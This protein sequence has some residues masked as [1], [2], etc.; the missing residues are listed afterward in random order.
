M[1][2]P[3]IIDDDY[4]SRN[5]ISIGH[6]TFTSHFDSGNLKSA[7]HLF[8]NTYEI[9]T[10]PDCAG[11]AYETDYTSWFHFGI[12]GGKKGERVRIR[13][14]K[15]N[16]HPT[17]YDN[18]MRPVYRSSPLQKKWHRIK[19]APKH[20]LIGG[21]SVLTF[22][23]V[24]ERA[25]TMACFAFCYPYS[26]LELQQK[27]LSLDER[28][29]KQDMYY[30]RELLI[31][32]ADG[33]RID[34]ITLS[35]KEGMSDEAEPR[36]PKL[37]P[38]QS[39]PRARRF[40][41]KRVVFVSAR[42]HPG[43]TP[44]SHALNGLLDFLLLPDDPRARSLRREFVF[45]IIPMLNPDGVARGHYRVDNNGANLNRYY[46][47][48]S[49]DQHGSIY[50]AKQIVLHHHSRA[51]LFMYLDLHAHATKRGCFVY[52]NSLKSTEQQTTNQLYARLVGINSANFEYDQC[53][54]TEKN[55]KSK[56][57]R[58]NGLSK[59]G[60][61]RVAV[62]RETG[63]THIYTLECNYNMGRRPTYLPA[64]TGDQGRASP[65][66]CRRTSVPKYRPED[67]QDVGKGLMVALLDMFELNPWTRIFKSPW[68]TY[69]GV[70]EAVEQ[71]IRMNTKKLARRR[72][73]AAGNRNIPLG[74]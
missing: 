2:D 24:F 58:D 41:N 36:I 33:R 64:A 10:S 46:Q 18:D 68:R 38:D 15:L 35:S 34:L 39:R 1:D 56:D 59:E 23:H 63:L 16:K 5:E 30:H 54:F 52:G 8:E 29:M 28:S 50:A 14:A 31:R 67:W 9:E 70:R 62:Y 7:R 3:C 42:V 61:G 12:R 25:D 71:G 37:F 11:T 45:K 74:R 21:R 49:I 44:A 13:I 66:I 43:E 32:S 4:P 65:E 60:S 20:E 73:A 51:E 47:N 22:E 53:N 69:E 27:L 48:P 26:Y 40:Q 55:M 72:P 6:L 19:R 17:L 57:K